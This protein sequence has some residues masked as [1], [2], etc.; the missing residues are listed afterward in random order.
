[1]RPKKIICTVTNDLTYDQR[2]QRICTSLSNAGYEVTLVGRLRKDSKPLAAF[3]FATK[4]MKLLFDKGKL[5]YIEYN[6]RLFFLLLF[7]KT[8]VYCAIDL[9]S[10]L[11]NYFASLFR[12][13]KRVYDAHELFCEMEE[14]IARPMIHK[15]WK[16]IERFAVPKFK[17]G[18]TIGDQYANEF[19]RLY[20][21]NYEVVRNAT[22]WEEKNIT[23]N[24]T[25]YI[26]YQGAVNE[27]RCFESLI[28]AM[29]YINRNIVI[30][31]NGNFF[32]QTKDL[33]KKYKLEDKVQLMGY[34]PPGELKEYTSK[35]CLGLTLFSTTSR[36]NYLSLANRFFD[37]MHF[38]V[39][40]IAP[41][42]PEYK[43][44]NEKYSIAK[45]IQQPTIE[46]IAAAINGVLENESTYNPM[47]QNA[48]AC[49]QVYNWQAEEKKLI[50]FYQRIFE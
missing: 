19:K 14:I 24:Y 41:D 11:P 22:I 33:I 45:L 7:I 2:M 25:S 13:K 4:R 5:F 44:I 17:D 26:L 48:I 38:G 39:P 34:V 20:Q 16:A 43:T 12:N 3:P 9:D 10:I 37:Y 49:A 29:Q 21:R 32:E 36:S 18:Y 28:P 8:D 15:A 50:Q 31:G 47:H 27:G 46:A 23:N 30:C 1:M 6:I 40:Q 35:A 42:Y